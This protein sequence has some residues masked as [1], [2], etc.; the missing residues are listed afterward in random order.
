MAALGRP[1]RWWG[2]GVKVGTVDETEQ[3]PQTRPDSVSGLW[4]WGPSGGLT[5]K[6]E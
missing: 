6:G 5:E 3:Q 4:A 1:S 2:L